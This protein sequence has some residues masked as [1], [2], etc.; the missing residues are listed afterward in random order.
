MLINYENLSIKYTSRY[1]YCSKSMQSAIISGI[2][3]DNSPSS[4]SAANSAGQYYFGIISELYNRWYG[5]PIPTHSPNFDVLF[6][7]WRK[8]Q[9]ALHDAGT[10]ATFCTSDRA[11]AVTAFWCPE[12]SRSICP[13]SRFHSRAVWS[14]DP[15]E[16]K[17]D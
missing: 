13:V 15:D 16:A 11:I 17:N 2:K 3:K 1:E 12:Y 10:V 5:R 14:D 6:A 7:D 9:R 4:T 8:R